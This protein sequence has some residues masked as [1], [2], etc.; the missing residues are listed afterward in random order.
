MNMLVTSNANSR[1]PFLCGWWIAKGYRIGLG[2]RFLLLL[3]DLTD[4][5]LCVQQNYKTPKKFHHAGFWLKSKVHNAFIAN[6]LNW[7][8]Y[9]N[10]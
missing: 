8:L 6:S 3:I 7:M 5:S 10:R 2:A 1:N 9:A 4:R